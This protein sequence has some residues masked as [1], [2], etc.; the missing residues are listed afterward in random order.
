MSGGCGGGSGWNKG[1]TDLF[2][3]LLKQ[4]HHN[5]LQF[6]GNAQH[7]DGACTITFNRELLKF[8]QGRREKEQENAQSATRQKLP[9]E[10]HVRS[11]NTFEAFSDDDDNE[12]PESSAAQ[13]SM[14]FADMISSSAV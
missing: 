11:F 1:G 7:D 13:N 9:T 10:Q 3:G 6:G 8:Y 4:V 12:S 2:D 5:R 14:L